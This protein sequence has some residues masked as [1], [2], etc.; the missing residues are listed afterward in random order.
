LP[1]WHAATRPWPTPQLI[2]AERHSL[3]LLL[4]RVR[5]EVERAE[6]KGVDWRGVIDSLRPV[7]TELWRGL[8][9]ADRGRFLRHLRPYWDVHR[10]RLAAPVADAVA[11]MLSS[12]YLRLAA[13]RVIAMR[14]G[15][16]EVEVTIRPRGQ[17][18]QEVLRVQRVISATGLQSAAEADSPLVE[19]LRRRGLARLDPWSFGLDVTD[20]LEV[21]DATGRPTGDLLALGPIVRGI[22]WEC[23]AVPDVR[24]QA[25]KVACR[26]EAVLAGSPAHVA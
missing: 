1:H 6:A 25:A 19:A 14:F 20:T 26:V 3:A 4:R 18:A 10:H 11:A 9:P 13:G 7:T 5:R 21:R 2:D 12:G 23:I 22:F 8:T 24:V 17:D 15:A 16:D